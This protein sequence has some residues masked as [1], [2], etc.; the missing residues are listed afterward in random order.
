MSLETRF[1]SIKRSSDQGIETVTHTIN[2]F[3][4][5]NEGMATVREVLQEQWDNR[6]ISGREANA[7]Y[8]YLSEVVFIV[9]YSYKPLELFHPPKPLVT[10][11]GDGYGKLEVYL[12]G[13]Y[14]E[15]VMEEGPKQVPDIWRLFS[16]NNYE[17][18]GSRRF[19][20]ASKG[21]GR[22]LDKLFTSEISPFLKS[23]D[24]PIVGRRIYELRAGPSTY[25]E[26]VADRAEEAKDDKME[27]IFHP[28]KRDS[29]P[30]QVTTLN[31][32]DE[33]WYFLNPQDKLQ[34]A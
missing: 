23:G 28:D 13:I 20:R 4:D 1:F 12:S 32:F 3:K 26:V 10:V 11:V 22:Y 14:P 25:L 18:R 30:F 7:N 34:V 5:F 19:H 27:I 6:N 31:R 16:V 17:G 29:K 33:Y 24:Y 21:T 8:L 2:Q 15:S 9:P